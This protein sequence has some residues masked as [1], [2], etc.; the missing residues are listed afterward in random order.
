V[1]MRS[2]ALVCGR[3]TAGIAGSG[4]ADGMVVH[5]LSRLCVA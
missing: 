4:L 2:N 5:F 3:W 1:A